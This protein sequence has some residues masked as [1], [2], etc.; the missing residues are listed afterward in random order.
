MSNHPN[1]LAMSDY[2]HD[3]ASHY[4]IYELA[5]TDLLEAI[6]KRGEGFTEHTTV[7][8]F[9]SLLSN[10]LTIRLSSGTLRLKVVSRS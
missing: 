5:E 7:Q 2:V 9:A 10:T 4:F 8:S 6:N 3:E 1:L